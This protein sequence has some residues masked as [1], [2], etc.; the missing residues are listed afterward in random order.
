MR[1]RVR[2]A[3]RYRYAELVATSHHEARLVPRTGPG[4]TVSESDISIA[5]TPIGRRER[6][7]YFGNRTL[8]FSLYEPHAE[9]EVVALSIVDNHQEPAPGASVLE[10]SPP[11]EQ[12]RDQLPGRRDA[13]ALAAYEMTFP[14]PRT[15]GSDAVQAA[16]TA[17]AA[18]SFSPG[19]PL[20]SAVR[21]LTGR[22]HRDFRYDPQATVVSTPL[23]NV[24][25]ERHGVCQDFAHLQ[26]ACLRVLGLPGRYVSGYLVT[27][28]SPGRERLIGADA[29]HAWV[30]VW[31]PG[32]GWLDFDPTNDL[33]PGDEHVTVAYGRDFG[34][35]TPLTGVILGGGAHEVSVGVDVEVLG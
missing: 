10:A 13:E 15:A 33:L 34:D 3:T 29:S 27:R 32:M 16:V 1:L 25:A 18:P 12:V 22:I 30:S 21:D 20:L 31:T 28:P 14:T 7:D 35:V 6:S 9:L 24:L 11:W 5:P 19:R 17:Y 8:S 23:E 26:L 2:H 4:A